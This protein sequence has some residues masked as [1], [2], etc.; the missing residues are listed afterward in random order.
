L[1]CLLRTMRTRN[2]NR[3]ELRTGRM[4]RDL[5]DRRPGA[6]VR[7][8]GPAAARLIKRAVALG[9]RGLCLTPACSSLS[10]VSR[11]AARREGGGSV[12]VGPDSRLRTRVP[13]AAP[14]GRPY[15]PEADGA[16]NSRRA[17]LRVVSIF[18]R[19][20]G[21]SE[22]D[23]ATLRS[24]QLLL[25]RLTVHALLRL[26]GPRALCGRRAAARRHRRRLARTS[27][28]R[29]R[30]HRNQSASR[31]SAQAARSAHAKYRG[32]VSRGTRRGWQAGHC[33]C[34]WSGW[35]IGRISCRRRTA[36]AAQGAED[37]NGAAEGGGAPAARPQAHRSLVGRRQL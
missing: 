16:C 35:R 14:R 3:N 4:K 20:G 37:Y 9:Q 32:G 34:S 26:R 27:A 6:H 19:S 33:C 11:M 31:P 29:A 17:A 36:T 2:K 8:S 18:E 24:D 23:D 21:E 25:R 5:F 13:R 7:R 22:R 12:S 30:R 15:G 28:C 1:C 10:H